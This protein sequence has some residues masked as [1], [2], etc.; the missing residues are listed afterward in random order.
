MSTITPAEH[1]RLWAQWQD[2]EFKK[3]IRTIRFEMPDAPTRSKPLT[4]ND[5][6]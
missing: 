6:G 5:K 3:W 2:E 1:E 4:L